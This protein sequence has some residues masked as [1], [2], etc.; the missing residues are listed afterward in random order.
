MDYVVDQVVKQVLTE[1]EAQSVIAALTEKFGTVA[2]VETLKQEGR[3]QK[4]SWRTVAYH[5]AGNLL[6][7]G[8]SRRS[9]Y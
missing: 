4:R 8:R 3:F 7:Y 5:T 6:R 9:Q 2:A 1:K